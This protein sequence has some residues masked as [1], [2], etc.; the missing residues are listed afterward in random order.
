[1]RVVGLVVGLFLLAVGLCV[2]V[3]VG[4]VVATTFAFSAIWT[5]DVLVAVVVAA[6]GGVVLEV[7]GAL[8]R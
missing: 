5:V 1:M 8:D 2:L 7:T 4:V 6:L 3:P